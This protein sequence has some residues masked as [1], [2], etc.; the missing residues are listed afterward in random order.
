[1]ARL[2]Q[3]PRPDSGENPACRRSR[4]TVFDAAPAAAGV[5]LT[6]APVLRLT[7]GDSKA[8]DKR[9]K[10]NYFTVWSAQ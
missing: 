2:L 7:A 5:N 10:L 1:M 4:R 6:A 3:E 8:G 9:V